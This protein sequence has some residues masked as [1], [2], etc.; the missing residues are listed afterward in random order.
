[1]LT[2]LLSSETFNQFL[3]SQVDNSPH[4]ALPDWMGKALKI[5]DCPEGMEGFLNENYI[6]VIFSL[7]RHVKMC[8][9]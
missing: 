2:I 6:F 4:H 9:F 7:E 1:L 3:S 8:I 5:A